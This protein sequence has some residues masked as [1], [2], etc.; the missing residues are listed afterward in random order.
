MMKVRSIRERRRRRRREG[1][2][3]AAADW[4]RVPRR[5]RSVQSSGSGGCGTGSGARGESGDAACSRAAE[6]MP[7]PLVMILLLLQLPGTGHTACHRRW[8]WEKQL[9]QHYG[10]VTSHARSSSWRPAAAARRRS[11]RRCGR[12]SLG[13]SPRRQEGAHPSLPIASSCPRCPCPH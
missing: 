9:C 7:P 11:L 13:H 6:C 3:D 5:L 1:A 2:S 12:V 8:R 4:K 10:W